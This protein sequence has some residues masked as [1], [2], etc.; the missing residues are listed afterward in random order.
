MSSSSAAPKISL[1]A[2]MD[3]SGKWRLM[4]LLVFPLKSRILIALLKHLHLQVY[5]GLATDGLSAQSFSTL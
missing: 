4:F 5:H 3:V 1:N 2:L